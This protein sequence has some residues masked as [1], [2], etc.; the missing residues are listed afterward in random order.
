MK[1]NENEIEKQP[2]FVSP[3]KY[4]LK[5]NCFFLQAEEKAAAAAA[6]ED[7]ATAQAEI[8]A[9]TTAQIVE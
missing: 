3:N 2:W 6:A 8:A 1:K 4:F 5:K 9:N 7:G